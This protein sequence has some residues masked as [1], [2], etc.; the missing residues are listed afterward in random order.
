MLFCSIGYDFC[1]LWFHLGRTLSKEQMAC[2][3]LKRCCIC[4]Q[5]FSPLVY[6]VFII[7][8]QFNSTLQLLNNVQK[9]CKWLVQLL[10]ALDYLHKNHILHRDVKVTDISLKFVKILNQFVSCNS[11]QLLCSWFCFLSG[12]VFKYISKEKSRHTFR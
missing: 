2:I 11:T 8:S 9:L 10:M 3:L 7:Y 6:N 5:L 12:S 4:T 1:M